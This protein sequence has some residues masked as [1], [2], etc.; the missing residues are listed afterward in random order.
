MVNP[1]FFRALIEKASSK[2]WFKNSVP[3]LLTGLRDVMLKF[4]GESGLK[5]SNSRFYD[6]DQN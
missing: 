5:L 1:N 3:W 4:S 6:G 2:C